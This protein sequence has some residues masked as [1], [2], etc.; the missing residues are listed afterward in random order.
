[1]EIATV[2]NRLLMTTTRA[3]ERAQL[4]RR[5]DEA[6]AAAYA[7]FLRDV[8]GPLARQLAGA[9]KAEGHAFTLFTPGDGLRLALDRSR[10]DY[11][12]IALETAGDH[13]QVVLRSSRTRGS[14]TLLDEQP[15]KAGA[16]V[17]DL[18]EDDLL[19]VLLS[20]LEPWLAR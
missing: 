8:A 4:R 1:M 17:Q 20:A 2:R 9:L 3:R 10:D 11:L 13:P 7:A 15:V 5:E 12:E 6:A 14:R 18:T 16:R 19:A